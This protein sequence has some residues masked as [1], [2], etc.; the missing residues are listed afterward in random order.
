MP[1][2]RTVDNISIENATIRFRNFSGK[3]GKYNAKDVRN[4]CVSIDTELAEILKA[5]GWNVR[6]SEPR[7]PDDEPLN[8]LQVAVSFEH[9]PPKIVYITSR[10]KATID[11]EDVGMLDWVQIKS[12]DVIIR[13]YN[14]DVSGKSGVKAYLKALYI[15]VEEDEF[16]SKYFDV[17]DSA[18][19]AF[20]DHAED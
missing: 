6:V 1:K 18:E 8:L 17:P 19:A 4:F 11:E 14:W 9:I 10:S 7:D 16:E 20:K 3:P 12:A 15:T 5:D 2:P 13:P